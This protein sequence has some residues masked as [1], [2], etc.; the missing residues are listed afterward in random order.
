MK[1]KII[2]FNSVCNLEQDPEWLLRLGQEWRQVVGVN[3][4]TEA[5][6]V[7]SMSRILRSKHR[8]AGHIS[9]AHTVGLDLW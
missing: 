7:G 8:E 5:K 9:E 1:V 2:V 4:P 6:C 3:W